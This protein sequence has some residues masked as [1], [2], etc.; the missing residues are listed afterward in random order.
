MLK[1]LTESQKKQIEDTIRSLSFDEKIGQIVCERIINFE[2]KGPIA[3][4]LKKYPVGAVY[5]GSEVIDKTNMTEAEVKAQ[6]DALLHTTGI[7]PVLVSDFEQGVGGQ[8]NATRFTGFPEAMAIAATGD[9]KNA[10]T[11]GRITA[12]E[13]GSI[14]V[15]CTYGTVTDLALNRDNPITGIRSYGDKPDFIIPFLLEHIRGLQEH[16]CAACAKHFPGD[17]ID[18][19]N[20]HFVTSFNPLTREE[21]MKSYGKVWKAVID[22]GVMSVMIGHIAMPQLE[23][24]DPV[25]QK[26]R[27]ATV[28]KVILQNL[29][30]GELGYRGLIISDALVMNGFCSWA[31]YD[32]RMMDAFNAGIDLFLWPDA[33]R[34]FDLMRRMEAQGRL[35]HERL[36]DA[37]RHVLEFKARLDLRPAPCDLPDSHRIAEKMAQDAL[38]LLRNTGRGI[39]LER[40]TDAVYWV[41]GTPSNELVHK[42]VNPF[43]EKLSEYGEVHYSALNDADFSEL[44][45]ADA[46]ILLNLGR[47]R[48][49]D[50]RGMSNNI[51]PFLANEKIRKRIVIGF[52]NPFFLYDVPSCDAYISAWSAHPAAQRE[53]VRVLFGESTCRGKSPV[54]I[55]GYVKAQS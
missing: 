26:Y 17:G 27:P 21:W 28:S 2:K 42:A 47:A 18:T 22:E 46:V 7:P 45:K 50:Y 24:M 48:F 33:E 10:Y 38:T 4:W 55:E 44:E 49:V 34:F 23:P 52:A 30:L 3:D 43:L 29:L 35:S 1:E 39:P 19:R 25:S 11:A 5:V 15:H 9:P 14:N 54:S 41:L 53:A 16:N 37:V 40:K 12:L 51:W 13:A 6:T 32:T 36:D 31:D 8:M 20:Q